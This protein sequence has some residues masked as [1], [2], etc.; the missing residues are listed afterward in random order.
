MVYFMC[1]T[2]QGYKIDFSLW[3]FGLSKVRTKKYCKNFQK[4]LKFLLKLANTLLDFIKWY[5]HS[6]STFTELDEMFE[7]MIYSILALA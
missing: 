2:S 1:Q 7:K 6:H 5:F 4:S 3:F